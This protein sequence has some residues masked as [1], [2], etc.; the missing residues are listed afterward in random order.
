MQRVELVEKLQNPS[1]RDNSFEHLFELAMQ[2][3]AKPYKIWASGRLDLR[4]I[5]LRLVFSD[6]LVYCREKGFLNSN[7][8]I[9]FN[10][11]RGDL[12]MALQN[13]AIRGRYVE[14]PLRYFSRVE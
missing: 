10:I 7:L 4:Q 8:S 6:Y 13:D 3:V 1:R 12:G 11:L 2:F 5:V 14:L 9:P